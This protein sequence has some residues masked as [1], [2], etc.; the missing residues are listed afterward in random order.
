[1]KILKNEFS[2]DYDEWVDP[3]T[4]PC[5]A[6]G[7]PL[8]SQVYICDVPGEFTI[9][10]EEGDLDPAIDPEEQYQQFADE[11][12]AIP[13]GIQVDEWCWWYPGQNIVT[14]AVQSFSGK[15]VDDVDDFS[16]D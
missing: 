1:M 3:G 4:Y 9:E 16:Y 7:Y 14:L 6:G 12:A 2:I 10:I 8:S 11:L 13:H 15:P 5:G